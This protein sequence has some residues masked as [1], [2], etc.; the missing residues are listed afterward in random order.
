MCV[1]IVISEKLWFLPTPMGKC[2]YTIICSDLHENIC[3]SLLLD[4]L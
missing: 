4:L 1:K 2:T 3:Q